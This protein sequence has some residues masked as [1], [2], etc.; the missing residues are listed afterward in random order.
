[1]GF[2]V[3]AAE[4]AAIEATY[5]DRAE[6]Y[7]TENRTEGSITRKTQKRIYDSL[8]CGLSYSGPGDGKQTR[9]QNQVEYD[10][11][12]FLAP[13]PEIAP[14]D[15]IRLVRLGRIPLAFSVVGRPAVYATHQEVK[16]REEALA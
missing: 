16:V 6:V 15:R 5:E 4:R 10:A 12:V 8:P 7:R 11:V 1:M 14:G 3:A 13:E 2:G 9:A